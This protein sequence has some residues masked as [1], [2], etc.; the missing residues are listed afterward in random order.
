MSARVYT[1]LTE[2]NNYAPYRCCTSTAVWQLNTV[3]Q[4]HAA[5]ATSILTTK[6]T[7]RSL[8]VQRISERTVFSFLGLQGSNQVIIIITIII[9]FIFL[10][11]YIVN[12]IKVTRQ[13][14]WWKMSWTEW[15][16]ER[17]I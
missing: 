4:Q 15:W 9:T 14:D 3:K 11:F 6:L 8:S 5:T 7:Y 10:T 12:I 17:N 2:L 16:G 13:E 1:E